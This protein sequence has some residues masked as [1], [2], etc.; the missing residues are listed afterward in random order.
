M[1]SVALAVPDPAPTEAQEGQAADGA[2]EAAS[3]PT[4]LEPEDTENVDGGKDTAS[5]AVTASALDA[6]YVSRTGKD[7]SGAG[8]E[9]SPVASL[10]KAVQIV[11]PGGTIYLQDDIDAKSLA[12]VDGKSMTIDGNGHTVT[13]S[14]DFIATND[15]GRGGY[16]PAM[17]E[18]ANGAKLT[19]RNITLDDQFRAEAESFELAFG[20]T[21][22]D[23]KVHDGIIASYGDGAATIVLGDKTTL[24]SFGGLSAVYITAR[25]APAPRS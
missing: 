1:P 17:I 10:A 24:K 11:N 6:V 9:A 8:T 14:D 5:G 19:L 23:L 18:V 20:T 22:N 21:G 13:R 25:T 7:E 3:A 4:T 12:L 16:N 2:G 15:G